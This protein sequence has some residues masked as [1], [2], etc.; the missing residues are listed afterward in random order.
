M[1]AVKLGL[2]AIACVV[3]IS[4]G[5]FVGGIFTEFTVRY[6]EMMHTINTLQNIHRAEVVTIAQLDARSTHYETLYNETVA[7]NARLVRESLD[8]T[9]RYNHLVDTSNSAMETM[10][11]TAQDAIRDILDHRAALSYESNNY[12]TSGHMTF[13]AYVHFDIRG[14][15]MIAISHP[16]FHHLNPVD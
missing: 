9:S 8:L 7:E 3:A 1:K 14:Q 5:L 13:S 10:A 6:A 16:T 12:N 4:I 15:R 11:T 2:W